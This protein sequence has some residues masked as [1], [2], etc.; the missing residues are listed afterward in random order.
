MGMIT[1]SESSNEYTLLY[2]TPLKGVSYNFI[3]FFCFHAAFL[4]YQLISIAISSKMKEKVSKKALT[5]YLCIML[6][7]L[8]GCIVEVVGYIG[9]L[10]TAEDANAMGPYITQ[11]LA[12]LISPV[13][14]AVTIY[15]TFN[16]FIKTVRSPQISG[17]QAR[18]LT[19]I[20]I[21][22]NFI[23]LIFEIAGSGMIATNEPSIGGKLIVVGLL[24]QIVLFSILLI[25]TLVFYIKLE[26][27]PS[28]IRIAAM[29]YPTKVINWDDLGTNSISLSGREFPSKLINWRTF[30]Y[31]LML[32]SI[33]MII[34]LVYRTVEFI[35][36]PAGFTARFED[37]FYICDSGLMNLCVV[38]ILAFNIP[39]YF[40]L[41]EGEFGQSLESIELHGSEDDNNTIS[42]VK[43]FESISLGIFR[44]TL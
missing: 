27:Q 13:F 39:N 3:A 44:E 24:I 23:S 42:R 29:Q 12:I 33:L 31:L 11:S 25:T 16:E 4:S 9:R 32:T 14:F 2:Y 26:R 21:T 30:C 20:L 17:T 34:R 28:T 5:K 38:C 40:I 43:R 6:P 36:G 35:E 8:V 18:C 41:H 15:M 10:Y 19:V 7:L 1:D 37:L 22:G